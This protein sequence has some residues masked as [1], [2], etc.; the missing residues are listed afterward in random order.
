[1]VPIT[2][3]ATVLTLSDNIALLMSLTFPSLPTFPA[4]LATEVKVPAVSKKSTNNKVNMT[5]D[6]P[7]VIAADKS[8]SKR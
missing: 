6:I 8:N 1:M 7:A 2:A 3:P 4:T 5:V